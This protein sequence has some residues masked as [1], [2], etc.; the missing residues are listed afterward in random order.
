MPEHADDVARYYDENTGAFLARGEGGSEGVLHRAV[1]GHGV[2]DRAGA[3][4]Y[5]HELILREIDTLGSP[6]PRILDLGCGVGSS[7]LYLLER[8]DAEGFGINVSGEQYERARRC[9]NGRWLR[10][11]FCRDPLPAEVDLA[12]GIES[13]VHGSDARAFFENVSRALRP[14]GRL[15]LVDDFLAGDASDQMPVRDFIRGW[16]ATS[17][18]RPHEVDA[19]AMAAGLALLFERDLTPHLSLDRPRDRALAFFLPLVRSVLSDGPRLRSLVGGN[20][21]RKCLKQGFI[22]YRFRVWEKRVQG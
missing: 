3:L 13:F 11:D 10:G 1:W 7:L 12:Y 6:R 22:E 5:V 21:L 19:M 16:L 14:R 9:G 17:L 15:V 2:V 20:A 8:R 4:H 18:L